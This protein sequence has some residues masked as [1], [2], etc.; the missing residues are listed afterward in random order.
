MNQLTHVWVFSDN[1]ER[2]AELMAGARQWGQQVHAIVVAERADNVQP[3][4]ADSMI[5]LEKQSE[6]F[7]IENYAETI[8]AQIKEQSAGQPSLLL[9]AATR[10]CKT[11]GSRLSVQLDAAM[12]NDATAVTLESNT[13][14]AEHRMYGGLAFGKE[15]LNS[16]LAIITLAPGVVEPVAANPAHRCPVVTAAYI[17][18]RHELHCQQRRAKSLSSVDLSKAK[19]VIGV[20]RGLVAQ[21]DL[22]MVRELAAVLGAEVGC[23][24]PIA[25]GENWMERERYI[26]VSGVLLKSDLYLTLGI[27][28]QIQHMVGGNG[29]KVIV[30]INKDKNAPIF[31]YADYGLVG[32]IYK[33]VPA[34]INQLSR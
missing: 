32:D 21:D 27:S 26:G 1:V 25:E 29:A 14:Y 6:L 12:V 18:P 30:A 3:L 20:G 5:V 11:L 33:V 8:A 4:G 15:K 13:I 17:A 34:L 22:S 7:C 28:G 19:R 10:R 23:S 9:M 16:S 2:Y 31:N 24:R